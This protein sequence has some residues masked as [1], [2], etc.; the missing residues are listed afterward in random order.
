MKE[1]EPSKERFE[2]A[3]LA[4]QG[5]NAE[6]VRE[7]AKR[8]QEEF[9][10]FPAPGE[11]A[12]QEKIESLNE[13]LSNLTDLNARMTS[14][15]MIGEAIESYRKATSADEQDRARAALLF[16]LEDL[17]RQVPDKGRPEPQTKA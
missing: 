9:S 14:L 2:W 1:H 16:V 11:V 5:R 4:E 7:I 3:L 12:L 13:A 6:D 10:H 17:D 8:I 15:R